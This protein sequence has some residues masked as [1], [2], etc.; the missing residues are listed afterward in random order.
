MLDSIEL[1]EPSNWFAQT[2]Q[3]ANRTALSNEKVKS[4]RIISPILTEVHKFYQRNISLFSGEELNIPP[5]NDL[6]GVCDFFF[7]ASPDAYLLE[8][9]LTAL[10]EAQNE[11]MDYGIAQYSA[12]ML[13]AQMFNRKEERA[14]EHIWGCAT[15]AHEWRF[16][17]LHDRQLSIGSETYFRQSIATL[18]GAFAQI[19][20]N[21]SS[22]LR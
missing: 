8:A 6:N 7:C 5:E 3:W 22:A 21:S 1:I 15:T 14:I 10:A 16:L 17:Q 12:Q 11:D 4:E 20:Q 2:L 19:I 9:P 18:L 13:A